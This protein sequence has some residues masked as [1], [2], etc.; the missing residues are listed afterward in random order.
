MFESFR[1]QIDEQNDRYE[2]LVKL[3]RDLTIQSKRIIFLLHRVA[4]SPGGKSNETNASS[5][6]EIPPVD[7]VRQAELRAAQQARQ[8]FETL[9]PLFAKIAAELEGQELE[10]FDRAISPGLQ[11]FLEALSFTHYLEH[12]ILITYPQVLAFL[13][14]IPMSREDYLLGVSDLSGELMRFAISAASMVGGRK[15]K[16]AEVCRFV[17]ACSGGWEPLTPYVRGLG[18]KQHV[19]IESLK[20]IETAAYAIAVRGAEYPDA[21]L[22]GIFIDS[23]GRRGGDEDDDG[24]RFGGGRQRHDDDDYMD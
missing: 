19:T 21:E 12:G 4:A 2:R 23:I 18:K 17:R 13:E 1:E 15:A 9:R 5:N 20:K 22:Q 11:E 7:P 24:R 16:V 6:Q 3:S 8:K 14:N 10:R